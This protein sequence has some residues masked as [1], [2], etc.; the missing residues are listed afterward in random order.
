LRFIVV[1]FGKSTATCKIGRHNYIITHLTVLER[2]DH[3]DLENPGATELLKKYHGDQQGIPFW[4]VLDKN[5]KLLADSQMRPEGTSLDTP[6]QNIGYPGSKEEIAAF[7]KVLKT[8]SSLSAQEL[9][10]IGE[11]FVALK[12]K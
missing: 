1:Y 12:G 9:S 11:R 5:G 2:D 3:K 4:L 8:T 10:L 6:G 7:Q